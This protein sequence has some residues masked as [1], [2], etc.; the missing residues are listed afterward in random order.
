VPE[1]DLAGTGI[2]D[3]HLVELE[4]FGT[5]LLVEANCLCHLRLLEKRFWEN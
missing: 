1:T 2:A 3:L 4:D 5:A